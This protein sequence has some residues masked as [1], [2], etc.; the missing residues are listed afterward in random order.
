GGFWGAALSLAT[1]DQLNQALQKEVEITDNERI[2]SS[3]LF[4][5]TITN[6]QMISSLKTLTTGVGKLVTEEQGIFDQID[7][8]MDSESQYV[9]PLNE[10]INLVDNT[11]T[12]GAAY[13]MIQLQIC[14]LI[15]LT[16]K[17]KALV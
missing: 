15:L 2:L 13:Q 5:I 10:R 8:I 7:T 16:E 3:S 6:A 12:L 17:V 11:P 9:E 4:N 1:E 14:L